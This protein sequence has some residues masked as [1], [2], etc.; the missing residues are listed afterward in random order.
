LVGLK[1][2]KTVGKKVD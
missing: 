1:D 2:V